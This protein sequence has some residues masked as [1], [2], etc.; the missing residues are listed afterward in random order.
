FLD[1]ISSS[2]GPIFK[3]I[4]AP[5]ILKEGFL[6]KRAQG[7]KRFG[8]KNF[9][10]RFFRLSNQTFSYSKHKGDKHNLFE[11]PVTDILAVER[12][13]EESFKMKYMFQVVHAE[14]AL[15]IQAN[16]CVEEKE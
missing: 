16:N 1:I 3:G 12:L 8:L 6:I 7:R 9:K 13:E 15:Y 10:K 4:E 5:I 2:S 11:I 14:R